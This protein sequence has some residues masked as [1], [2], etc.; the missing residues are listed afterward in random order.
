MEKP[1]VI[2]LKRS[3]GQLA[4]VNYGS[5]V[6]FEKRTATRTDEIILYLSNN[7]EIAVEDSTDNLS[8][9]LRAFEAIT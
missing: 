7:T 5:I 8:K 4:W 2:Q 9:I 6:C 3:N 1:S